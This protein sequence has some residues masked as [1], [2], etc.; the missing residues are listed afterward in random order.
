MI[1]LLLACGFIGVGATN[2]FFNGFKHGLCGMWII[3]TSLVVLAAGCFDLFGVSPFHETLWFCLQFPIFP[4]FNELSKGGAGTFFK[5]VPSLLV[6]YWQVFGWV[7]Q[8]FPGGALARKTVDSVVYCVMWLLLIWATKFSAHFVVVKPE[9]NSPSDPSDSV[10]FA[11]IPAMLLRWLPAPPAD[12]PETD[13]YFLAYHLCFIY[14]LHCVLTFLVAAQADDQGHY[15]RVSY[16]YRVVPLARWVPMETDFPPA[17]KQRPVLD[18]RFKSTPLLR[19][20]QPPSGSD[21]R[22]LLEGGA[23][24]T[25]RRSVRSVDGLP[26]QSCSDQNCSEDPR[27]KLSQSINSAL[28]SKHKK[29]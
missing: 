3:K 21:V 9:L 20:P 26:E 16:L 7:L 1:R 19:L 27:S 6:T 5:Y 15:A 4:L 23:E 29:D 14:T 17:A 2:L 8:N 22:R 12:S 13:P 24:L 10:W 25:R 18:K 11:S 28:S